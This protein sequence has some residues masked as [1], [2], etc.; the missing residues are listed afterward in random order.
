M[1]LEKIKNNQNGLLFYGMTPPKLTTDT[2][3]IKTIASKQMARLKGLDIDGV[4][5]YDIQDETARTNDPRPFPFLSTLDPHV[6]SKQ[7]LQELEVPKIIY[8]SVGKYTADDLKNWLQQ[9]TDTEQVVFV[10]APSKEQQT[11]LSLQEAYQIKREANPELLLGGVTIPERH[12]KKGDEHIRLFDKMD[13]G[14]RF[15]VSQCVYNSGHAKDFLSD[16]YYASKEQGRDLVP[17]IF[18]LTPCGSQ[19]SLQFMKWLGVDIPSWLKNELL[20]SNDI[21]GTSIDVCKSIAAE[22]ISYCKDK[23]MPVGFNIESVAIRKE[24]IEASIALVSDIRSM[25]NS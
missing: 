25:M 17:I 11:T 3:K 14:C 15:F 6:Y 16:Y 20:A 10:G 13:K 4:I 12:H 7:Y 2:E 18:T 19:K 5:L 1:L 8:K 23:N 22:I 21:L 9:G 24:E